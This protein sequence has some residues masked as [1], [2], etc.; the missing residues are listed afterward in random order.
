MTPASLARLNQ[1]IDFPR[2]PANRLNQ[3]LGYPLRSLPPGI[4]FSR[5]QRVHNDTKRL[6]VSEILI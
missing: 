5:C 3:L 1:R 2:A 4:A 6:T